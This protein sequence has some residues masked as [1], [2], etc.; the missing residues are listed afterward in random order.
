MENRPEDEAEGDSKK[1]KKHTENRL[2]YQRSVL[3][4]RRSQL[5]RILM[6]KLSIR[7]DLS[8]SKQ[9][10]TVMKENLGQFDD[11]LQ[12]LTQVQQQHCR[13]LSEEEHTLIIS[14]LDMWMRWYFH[15]NTMFTTGLEKTRRI[16]NLYLNI[17]QS[18]KVMGDHQEQGHHHHQSQP[19]RKKSLKRS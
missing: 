2:Q 4:D 12:F 16:K 17:Q 6:R 13:L 15:L 7:D 3:E 11:V 5:H 9:N 1:A 18:Q 8:Y 10:L 19:K 14:G